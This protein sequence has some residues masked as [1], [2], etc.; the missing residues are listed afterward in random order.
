[1]LIIHERQKGTMP[2]WSGG[3]SPFQGHWARK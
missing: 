1:M 3:S 2:L